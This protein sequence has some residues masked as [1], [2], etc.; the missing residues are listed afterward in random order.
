MKDRGREERKGERKK[1]LSSSCV[2]ARNLEWLENKEK[3][4]SGL[5]RDDTLYI[6]KKLR[7]LRDVHT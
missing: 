6:D 1:K 4:S 5:L 7:N 2:S 3:L